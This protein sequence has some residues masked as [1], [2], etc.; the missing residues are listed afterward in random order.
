MTSFCGGAAHGASDGY[1]HVVDVL[2]PGTPDGPD[3]LSSLPSAWQAL[4]ANFTF[5][6]PYDEALKDE[7]LA[8]TYSNHPAVAT[9]STVERSTAISQPLRWAPEAA[10]SILGGDK[11]A[12]PGN[13]ALT[14]PS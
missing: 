4:T 5:S 6:T 8:W 10:K 14:G 9:A 7:V 12:S 11:T 2:P 3:D 13:A 1:L